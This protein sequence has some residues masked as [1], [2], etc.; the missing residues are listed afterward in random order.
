MFRSIVHDCIKLLQLIEISES[1][2]CFFP[3]SFLQSYLLPKVKILNFHHGWDI[4]VIA[5][6]KHGRGTSCVTFSTPDLGQDF[7]GN[8]GKPSTA[9]KA[10]RDVS[11]KFANRT[12]G[13][14]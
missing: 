3:Y 4:V 6:H 13:I 7:I 9:G 8:K 5:R 11:C 12:F 14:I 10:V 2:H 1:L